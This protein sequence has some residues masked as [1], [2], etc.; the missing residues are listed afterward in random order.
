[1]LIRR[2]HSSCLMN[3][4]R[5]RKSPALDE[6]HKVVASQGSQGE[7]AWHVVGLVGEHGDVDRVVSIDRHVR[8]PA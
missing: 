1:M 3:M 4:A 5:N 8:H 6:P 2:G 7:E